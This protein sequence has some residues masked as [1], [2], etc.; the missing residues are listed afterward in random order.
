MIIVYKPRVWIGLETFIHVYRETKLWMD[1]YCILYTS[2]YILPLRI[3]VASYATTFALE[4]E[5]EEEPRFLSER[6]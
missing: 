2:K 3:S 6:V 1:W 4:G 5:E